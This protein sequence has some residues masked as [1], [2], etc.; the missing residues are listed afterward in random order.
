M[1]QAASYIRTK[2]QKKLEKDNEDYLDDREYV[3]DSIVMGVSD[4]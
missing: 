2:T 3:A 1:D 4:Y